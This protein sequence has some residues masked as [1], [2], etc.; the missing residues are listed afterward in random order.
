MG[1]NGSSKQKSYG[2]KFLRW[3]KYQP[4]IFHISSLK[5]LQV[6]LRKVDRLER[7]GFRYRII[8]L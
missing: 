7:R 8:L 1:S 3:L 5:E 6:A 2:L 4:P